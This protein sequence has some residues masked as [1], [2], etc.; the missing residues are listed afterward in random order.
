MRSARVVARKDLVVMGQPYWNW[1]RP[2]GYNLGEGLAK[3][4][5]A[6]EVK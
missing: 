6:E 5:T 4:R 1:E 2:T 3:L